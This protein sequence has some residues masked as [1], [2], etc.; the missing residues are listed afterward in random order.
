MSRLLLIPKVSEKAIAQAE[1][2][3]YIFEV[4]VTA[5]KVEVAKAVKETFKVDVLSVNMLIA[6]GKTK[7]FRR[8]L[9]Q[10]KDIKKA[11]VKI[12][13]GQSIALFEGAK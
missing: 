12:K 4:P 1:A 11:I 13:K 3:T 8:V 10:E 9:G 6:K 2:A 7:R 5:N